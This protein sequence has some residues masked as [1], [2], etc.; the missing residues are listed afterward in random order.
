ME[1]Q[2]GWIRHR[3]A[4]LAHIGEGAGEQV[5][6][7]LGPEAE[8]HGGAHIKGVARALEAATAAT[9]DEVALEHQGAGPFGCKLG[10]GDQPADARPDHKH[11]PAGGPST[12]PLGAGPW[13]P[14]LN[15][16][17]NLRRDRCGIWGGR[18]GGAQGMGGQRQNLRSLQSE[19]PSRA[20][21]GGW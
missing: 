7:A 19:G 10:G 17:R 4:V 3:V 20:D 9:W 8:D 16:G 1:G 14:L 18:G 5:G 15:A 2:L 11:I 6:V 13:P 21:M 12:R